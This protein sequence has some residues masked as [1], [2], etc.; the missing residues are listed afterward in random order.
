MEWGGQELTVSTSCPLQLDKLTSSV[1]RDQGST[2]AQL[3]GFT[4]FRVWA[5][6]EDSLAWRVIIGFTVFREE[7]GGGE[8]REEGGGRREEGG[9]RRE[10]RRREEG[11]GR[12]EERG[13]RREEGRREE[14]GGGR[15]KHW[16]LTCPRNVPK[17]TVLSQYRGKGRLDQGVGGGAGVEVKGLL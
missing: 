10:E 7:E 6:V 8:E 11:G 16:R 12:R 15:S 4:L 9:G 17:F 13:G 3:A 2:T 14:E 1:W 5:I